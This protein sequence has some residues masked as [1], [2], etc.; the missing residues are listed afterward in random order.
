MAESSS[1]DYELGRVL[2]TGLKERYE[3]ERKGKERAGVWPE[4][5]KKEP[6]HPSTVQNERRGMVLNLGWRFKPF[7]DHSNRSLTV[8]TN[9][10]PFKSFVDR[11]WPL[12]TA[13]W[14]LIS[15][16][17]CQNLSTKNEIFLKTSSQWQEMNHQRTIFYRSSCSLTVQF[18]PNHSLKNISLLWA[19]SVGQLKT[20]GTVL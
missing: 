7:L 18:I 12:L 20:D 8:L 15:R 3:M 9:H 2:L 14:L 10:W 5:L 4:R 6:L 13:H 11:C 16:F 17:K 1:S 19:L